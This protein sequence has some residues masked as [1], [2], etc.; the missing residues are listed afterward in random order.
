MNFCTY[1]S[2]FSVIYVSGDTKECKDLDENCKGDA[3]SNAC[4]RHPDYM[5]QNCKEACEFCGPGI[6]VFKTIPITNK[7][8]LGR[9]RL[10][11]LFLSLFLCLL[12]QPSSIV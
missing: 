2:C 3:K 6:S 8:F 10:Y 4:Q 9:L 11:S 1:N 12:I 7:T 5:L